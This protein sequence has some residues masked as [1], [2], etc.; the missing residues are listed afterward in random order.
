MI[1]DI[2]LITALVAACVVVGY[3]IGSGTGQSFRDKIRTR[4][5]YKADSVAGSLVSMVATV[6]VVSLIAIPVLNTQDIRPS[7]EAQDFRLVAATNELAPNRT[8][9]LPVK[10]NTLLDRSETPG[11]TV[12][13]PLGKREVQA[14]D[15][16]LRDLPDVVAVAPSV[17]KVEGTAAQCG[18]MQRGSGFV[19]APGVVMTNAH[20]VAGTNKVSLS[21]VKGLSLI[22]I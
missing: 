17:V 2:V 1:L 10:G 20:V 5:P 4:Q 18:R 3:F 12:H 6:A 19:V 14:P 22:H 21:T 9:A 7:R 8:G 15:P 11:M 13:T 16:A